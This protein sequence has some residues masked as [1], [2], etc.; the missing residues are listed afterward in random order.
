[1][2]ATVVEKHFTLDRTLPGPDHSASLTVGELSALVRQI[3]DVEAALGSPV[4]AP[5]EVELPVR[6]VVRRSVTARRSLPAGH[7]LT[8]ADLA[9]LRPASGL[10]PKHIDALPGR[11]LARAVEAGQPLT[12]DHLA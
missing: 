11:A 6:A 7:V 9:L 10:E 1:M 8:A 4:K 3:R 2:G 5:T 12:W